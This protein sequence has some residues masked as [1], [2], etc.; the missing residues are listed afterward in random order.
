MRSGISSFTYTWAVGV[1]GNIPDHP[2]TASDLLRTAVRLGAECVQIADNFPLHELSDV[3]LK[4]LAR[5]SDELD[6]P[7]EVGTRGLHPDNLKRYLNIATIF[8]S[9]ILRMVISSRDFDPSLDEIHGIIKDFIPELESR[10][11]IL[12]IENYEKFS[13][14]DFVAMKE[15][16]GSEYVGICLD[17]VNSMGAGEG[18]DA[19][20]EH[21]APLTVNLHIK[22]FIVRRIDQQMGFVIEGAPL[23]KGMLPLQKILERIPDRCQSAILEQWVP[24]EKT[25]GKTIEKEAEWAEEGIEYLKALLTG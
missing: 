17:T 10:K 19:V 14:H 6:V 24:P 12:A 22:E 3:H 25:M 2:M 7:I 20:I 23:G 5:F 15:K 4:D 13:L 21:L 18:L 8:K 16:A 11:I 1:P 9:P